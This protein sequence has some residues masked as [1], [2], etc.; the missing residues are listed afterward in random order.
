MTQNYDSIDSMLRNQSKPEAL[1]I[2][3]IGV[4]G[5]GCNL[6]SG[7]R[8]DGFNQ[9][10]AGAVD[11]DVKAMS[12]CLAPEKIILGRRLTGGFG[13]GGDHELGRK[14]LEDEIQSVRRFVEGSDLL[15]LM[16]GLG[17]GIG[18]GGAPLVAQCAKDAGA[19]VFSFVTTP[20]NFESATRRRL[21]EES[22]M[23]L[24]QSSNAVIPLSNDLLLQQD[25]ED[26]SLLGCFAASNQW[27]GR[28]VRSLCGML[29]GSGLVSVDFADL[30]SAF[31]RRSG[32]TLFGLGSGEG[33]DALHAALE[34]LLLSPLLHVP[35]SSRVADTLLVN[36]MGGPGLG[37][38]AVNEVMKTLQ[39]RFKSKG[40]IVFGACVEENMGDRAEICVIGATDL[41]PEIP[42]ADVAP[43]AVSDP[44]K[45]RYA[46]A[47]APAQSQPHDSKLRK[48]SKRRLESD[49][50]QSEF[51]FVE[52]EN[53]R[54]YF[55][56]T[57]R[58][59]HEDE[60]L[61]VPTYLRRGIKVLS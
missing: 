11:A 35:D 60:D 3:A 46:K 22:I 29:D 28:G 55:D 15:F 49:R 8:L 4:G 47:T 43:D 50:S 56:N 9:V 16:A 53:Q 25:D 41:E 27:I 14:V 45:A 17:G 33:P 61:D 38:A 32:R 1:R 42:V 54:G 34:D 20:F 30:R 36:V 23:A 26:E 7:L 12:E 51:N 21:A 57:E 40:R 31:S 37:M 2:R 39:E 59:M 13:A 44:A 18:S 24:R 52:Q 19:V 6:A 48:S 10:M 5:A 58:N